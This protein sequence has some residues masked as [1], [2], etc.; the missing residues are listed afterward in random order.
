MK[1]L[2]HKKFG[3]I[4]KTK[5]EEYNTIV[6]TTR[7]KEIGKKSSSQEKNQKLTNFLSLYVIQAKNPI[8]IYLFL[9]KYTVYYR[10]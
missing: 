5:R 2:S 4:S 1:M 7:L 8:L 9:I 3:R 10:Y 6:I